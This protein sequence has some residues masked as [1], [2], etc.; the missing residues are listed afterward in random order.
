MKKIMMLSLFSVI[1]LSVFAQ[2]G[3]S[4][5]ADFQQA[6]AK[7]TR[8][9]TGKPGPKYWQNTADYDLKVDFEP[10]SGLLK[11]TVDVIYKNQ[12]PDTLK[13]VWFKLYPNLYKDGSPRSF[14]VADKDL[15]EGVKIGS[16]AI[17]DKAVA[18]ES[19]VIDGTNMHTSIAALAPGKS[20]KVKISYQYTLNKGSHNRTGMVDEGSY[21]VAYF[22]PRIAVYDD[23]DGWN[24]YPYLGDAE[25][26][27]DFC[28]FKAAVTV[29]KDYVIWAT[30]DL[31]NAKNVFQ[32]RIADRLA[33]AEQVD[34]VVNVI[35]MN[36]LKNNDITKNQEFN[37]WRFE[38]KNVTDFVFATSNHYLWKSS[39]LIVDPKTKRR[40]R[41]DAA[42]NPIHK[43]YYEVVDFARK[44]VDAMSYKFPKW[45]FP[46]AHETVFDGLDQMEYPMMVND[47]PVDKR[48]NGITLTIHEIFHTMFPFYMGINETKYGWMD[49]G[50]ATI[51]EW[52]NSPLIEPTMVDLYGIQPTGET[53][54]SKDDT[55][56]MTLTPDLKGSGTFTNSYPKPALGYLYVKDYLGDELFT[57]ALHHYIEAW[58][59]K[60]P[61]PFDFFYSMNEGSGK[62]MDWF[63]KPWFFG[64]GDIDLG[65]TG[66]DKTADGYVFKVENKSLK[67]LPVD[68]TLTYE[69]GS[70]E[71][72]HKSI[73][74]WQ[75]AG[76]VV[77]I[78]F[79]T[80]KKI[81][82]V[83]IGSTYVPDKN[84]YNNVLTVN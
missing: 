73:G 34:S 25:F 83:M 79:K 39:S 37:T 3:L 23:V 38:A 11:G 58:H 13:E 17:N 51:G 41:V 7:G 55:P 16:I 36:D 44:S 72:L 43:D 32:K 74:I 45:P 48:E 70:V 75:N 28:T 69:D 10:V 61:M 82:R 22:F 12:S 78:P 33:L 80:D 5:P 26:Y 65:I 66:A 42:F 76:Q 35:D 57:K 56:V 9:V 4:V 8:S 21:F 62:N 49:E 1:G 46:Y 63:W 54:G 19:L 2:Q 18:T 50:W 64:E 67:P 52:L 14:K 84:E 60:H 6:Y 68:L 31:M 53:S 27:N 20:M 77:S 40:T 15:S 71:K 81:K 59:G 24:K 47:N 29:P 30:G